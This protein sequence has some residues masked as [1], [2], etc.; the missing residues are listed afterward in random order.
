MY[1]QGVLNENYKNLKVSKYKDF[2]KWSLDK[3]TSLTE[4]VQGLSTL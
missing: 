1:V 2:N 4:V 3:R